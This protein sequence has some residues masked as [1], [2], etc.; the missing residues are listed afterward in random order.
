MA[1]VKIYGKN[2]YICLN[3]KNNKTSM[4]KV[5]DEVTTHTKPEWLK[6]RLHSSEGYGE[7]A[8]IVG[9]HRLH[10]ICS[11]GMCPNKAECWS[12]RTATLMI[13]GEVC[14]R[15][16][17]FCATVTGRPLPPDPAEP[18][19]VAES[20]RLMGLRHAVITSVTRDDLADRG[21]AHW[22]DVIRRVREVNPDTTI[23]VLVPDFDGR[24]D[25]LDAVLA[26]GPDIVGHNIETVRRLT[27]RVRS[28]ARYDVS[29]GV[30]RY[31]AA[32]GAV[33]KSGLMAG[34]GE[35]QDEVLEAFDDLRAAGC[36]IVTVGQYLQPTR[37]HMPVA[38]YV[39]PGGFAWYREQALARGFDYAE[40][41]PLVRSSYMAERALDAC[42]G[43][44]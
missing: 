9:E 38:A 19:Q 43:P 2:D 27:P 25:L 44:K 7:V 24:A 30:L 35:T 21:V 13:L 31:L 8:R 5:Y 42:R 4:P 1:R 41:G 36:R 34:L 11:S 26:A 40:C 18:R 15:A 23:E 17:R 29:L 28:R 6:I 16:C 37:A 20:I 3:W 22:A 14:T 39:T 12:R 33:V 32:R 10:T